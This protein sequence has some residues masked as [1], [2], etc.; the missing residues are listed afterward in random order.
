MPSVSL[1][2]TSRVE[3]KIVRLTEDDNCHT[4]FLPLWN[5]ILYAVDLQGVNIFLG[6]VYIQQP[7]RCWEAHSVLVDK[8]LA[9][10]SEGT[11]ES[12]RRNCYLIDIP[13][14]LSCEEK[15]LNNFAIG[16][17]NFP[18]EIHICVVHSFDYD[19]WCIRPSCESQ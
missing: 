8:A 15:A 9:Q 19:C 17:K 10:Q 5:V 1:R 18:Y 16:R 11:S 3:S 14:I 12:P 4:V 7:Q 2:S 13:Q 6:V